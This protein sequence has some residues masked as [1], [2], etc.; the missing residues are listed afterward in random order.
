MGDDCV[1][2]LVAIRCAKR[3]ENGS[4]RVSVTRVSVQL[5]YANSHPTSSFCLD[6]AYL[7]SKLVQVHSKSH[8]NSCYE[9]PL[10]RDIDGLGANEETTP[11]IPNEALAAGDSDQ[12]SF[13]QFLSM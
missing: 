3:A 5:S 12:D 1:E 10:L 7:Y 9:H 4:E 13:T 2:L 6:L 11:L 8:S